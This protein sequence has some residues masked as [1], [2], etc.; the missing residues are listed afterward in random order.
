MALD[1]AELGAREAQ[2]MIREGSLSPVTL[3]EACLERIRAHDRTLEAWVH[4]DAAGA[5]A[6]ARTRE[7]EARAGR[8]RGAMHGVPVGIKDIFDVAGMPTRAGAQA[9]AHRTPS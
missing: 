5:L 2:F 7:T 1:P 8:G 4:V 6:T 3:V 9:H